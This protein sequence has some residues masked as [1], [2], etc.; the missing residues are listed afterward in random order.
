MWIQSLHAAA[1]REIWITL[2]RVLT[3]TQVRYVEKSIPYAGKAQNE[4]IPRRNTA[5]EIVT[6][7]TTNLQGSER[8][9]TM[10]RFYTNV[11]LAEDMYNKNLI[12]V[13]T[14]Q[15]NKRHL[16]QELKDVSRREPK[17]SK[18]AWKTQSPVMVVSHVP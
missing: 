1:A 15:K 10:D 11:D 4:N 18:F 2:L 5:S 9:V 7:L 17:S 8:N 16:P 14:I 13:R 3:D 12:V 6:D